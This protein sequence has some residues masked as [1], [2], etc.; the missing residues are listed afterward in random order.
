MELVA[1]NDNIGL[2]E[3]MLFWRYVHFEKS[4]SSPLLEQKISDIQYS[5]DGFAHDIN[6]RGGFQGRY[7]L[8]SRTWKTLKCRTLC[9]FRILL[10]S[11]HQVPEL[12]DGQVFVGM[13]RHQH[14]L[15]RCTQSR[16]SFKEACTGQAA[17]FLKL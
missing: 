7:N 16:K 3:R 1:L 2:I 17:M 9:R 6:P 13:Q 14:C 15:P 5:L 12:Q 10:K 11:A 4:K 8:S